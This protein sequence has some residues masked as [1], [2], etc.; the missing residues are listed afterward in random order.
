MNTLSRRRSIPSALPTQRLPSRSSNK[1]VTGSADQPWLESTDVPPSL[2]TR[3]RPF[4]VPI[5]TFDSRSRAMV[6][7]STFCKASDEETRDNPLPSQRTRPLSVPIHKS[8]PFSDNNA[9][10]FLS[11]SS[12]TKRETR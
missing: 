6:T 1:A 5:Q 4:E 11:G 2:L 9:L 3:A 7:I 8:R 10:T 12:P